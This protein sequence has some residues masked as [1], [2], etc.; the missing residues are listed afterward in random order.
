[1]RALARFASLEPQLAVLWYNAMA[2]RGIDRGDWLDA[3]QAGGYVVK[4]G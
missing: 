4:T 3:E 1:M 2:M